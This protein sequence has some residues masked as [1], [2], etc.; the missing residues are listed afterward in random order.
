MIEERE[1]GLDTLVNNARIIRV[2]P[3]NE[4]SVEEWELLQKVNTTSALLGMKAAF[5]AMARRGGG[6]IINIASTAAH[7][8]AEAYGA[9]SASKAAV[10]ALTRAAGL[11][12]ASTSSASTPSAPAE[13]RRYE[14]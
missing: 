8:A 4:P 7:R 10:I 3:L 6:T 11:E 9:Y 1:A 13:S 2:C 14:R 5:R 12:F